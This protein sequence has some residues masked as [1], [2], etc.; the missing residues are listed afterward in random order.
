MN[1]FAEAKAADRRLAILQALAEDTAHRMNDRE[2]QRMLHL[3][4]HDMSAGDVR[5]D[6]SWLAARG[7]LTV[8]QVVTLQ[9]A[10]LTELGLSTSK[11]HNHVD[12]V[13]LPRLD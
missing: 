2:L 11:G 12:G 8:E 10:T 9:I 13:A 1:P 3:F 5:K 7:L 4:G 6:L